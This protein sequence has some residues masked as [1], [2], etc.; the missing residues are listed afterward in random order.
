MVL[1][2]IGFA[3]TH[4]GQFTN[5]ITKSHKD[6]WWY[7]FITMTIWHNIYYIIATFE[8]YGLIKRMLKGP[9]GNFF[10][11]YFNLS[12]ILLTIGDFGVFWVEMF[13]PYLVLF[14]DI[15]TDA[16]RYIIAINVIADCFNLM[17]MFSRLPNVGIYIFMMKR[18]T[19][20]I[21]RFLFTYIWHFSPEVDCYRREE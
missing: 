4:F 1:S 16:K 15:S 9:S 20:S 12:N 14:T 17:R 6:F 7:F 19:I 13:F 10:T 11:N 5:T 2:L 3:L 18:V 21:M 8:G